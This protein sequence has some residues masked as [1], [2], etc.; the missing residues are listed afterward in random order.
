MGGR[1]QT[2]VTIWSEDRQNIS[3][4]LLF[5]PI[6][7]PGELIYS[8][9][10]RYHFLLGRL[11]G[12]HT[13][14]STIAR[15]SVKFRTAG[16]PSYIGAFV[17]RLPT[18]HPNKD[19]DQLLDQHTVVPMLSY[20]LA[21][22]KRKKLRQR[23]VGDESAARAFASLGL[24]RQPHM[25]FHRSLAFCPTCV[26]EDSVTY[27]IAHWHVEHQTPGTFLC[28][29]HEQTLAIGCQQCGLSVASKYI[30]AL[31]SEDCVRSG[32]LLTF[33]EPPRDIPHAELVMLAEACATLCN[34]PDGM[35]GGTWVENI[36]ALLM[37]E[38]VT[39]LSVIDRQK[40]RERLRARFSDGLLRWIGFIKGENASGEEWLSMVLNWRLNQAALDCLVLT[41]AFAGT[42]ETFETSVQILSESDVL[43][44]QV[45]VWNAGGSERLDKVR[46]ELDSLKRSAAAIGTTATAILNGDVRGHRA[47]Q[48][49]RELRQ[50]IRHFIV[51]AVKA[52]VPVSGLAKHLLVRRSVVQECIP[53][54][55]KATSEQTAF[56]REKARSRLVVTTFLSKNPN[57]SRTD[58]FEH[59]K[60]CCAWLKLHDEEWFNKIR[61]KKK[62]VGLTP[63]LGNSQEDAA[64]ASR[65]EIAADALRAMGTM[66]RLTKYSI[67][68]KAQA[69][70]R[71]HHH[72]LTMRKSAAVISENIESIEQWW[73]R[74]ISAY[75]AQA[76]QQDSVI[77]SNRIK[78]EFHLPLTVPEWMDE[79]IRQESLRQGFEWTRKRSHHFHES[80]KFTKSKA[81][82]LE[83]RRNEIN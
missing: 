8:G 22:T 76:G 48:R 23:F 80:R 63:V 47:D 53:D 52:G 19:V 77:S 31:P 81:F 83:R 35:P 20:F 29:K 69:T 21:P 74:R 78:Q 58:L 45:Q 51:K 64:L 2:E 61:P 40:V 33:V 50:R 73:R 38:G 3:A 82:R 14:L 36:K 49:K 56:E 13:L 1:T 5:F 34:R 70:S 60:T 43:T 37:K 41:I 39:R 57:A 68:T 42:I 72:V 10:G 27:G 54:D 18:H 44:F 28:A 26:L 30:P 32:H 25:A 66:P 67:A 55:L 16:A 46:H 4:Q 71:E 6:L 24:T 9:L 59:S 17:E 79:Y 65:L 15:A 62:A 7:R 12:R 75:I 11:H